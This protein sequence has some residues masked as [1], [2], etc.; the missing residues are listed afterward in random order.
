MTIF[1][2]V[3]RVTIGGV[4]YQTAILANL[5]IT[6]GRTNIYEQAQ[7]GY[8]NLELINLDQSNVT[9]GIN[10]SVTIELQNSIATF[11]PIFGGSVVDVGISVAEV[12]SV[13]YAQR[14]NIIALGALA[15]LPKALTDGVLPHDFDG[16][17]IFTILSQV[18][19]ASWAEVPQAL[20]WANYDA[21]TQWQDAENTGLGEIDRPGNYELAQRSS[22]RTDVYS[23]V[24]ALAS[25]G[26]GYI[27]EDSFG[28]I[29]YAD[30]THRTNYLAANGYVDLTAN[31][32]VASGLSIQ[33]R[34]GDVRN[35]ITIKYGQNSQNETDA[36]DTESIALY[37]QLSQI[38]TTTLRHLAD[39]EDQAD[40]YLSLRAYPRFN[41]NNI[42]FEL[43]NPEID[44]ADRDALINVFMGMPVNI[45]NLPLN[46]NSGDF[47][48][49][50]EGWTFAARYNQVSISM[51]VSPIAFSLQAM[52]W[53]DVPIVEAWNT[54]NPTLDWINATIVA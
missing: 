20:T 3:W 45:A 1:N 19:F 37:G 15:R 6:S 28:R 42:T 24:S 53:N 11:V 16:D 51:I 48:G 39:A 47:L 26:L 50:V 54:V 8:V 52:R 5:T 9:I 34:T 32:A 18:L 49:F 33:Q 38:F 25:S 46:M 4:Q 21:T 31:H 10:D 35:N 30:S 17:Q 41:F 22:S 13:D 7:A 2:P 14:I 44:D 36:S 40:F 27:Y 23:L 12:G 29:G 43:T